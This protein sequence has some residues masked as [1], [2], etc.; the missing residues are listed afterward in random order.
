[1][2]QISQRSRT[3]ERERVKKGDRIMMEDWI[4]VTGN[5]MMVMGNRLMM[6]IV[7]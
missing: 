5:W 7:L 6:G 4:M 1:M 2:T 3:L